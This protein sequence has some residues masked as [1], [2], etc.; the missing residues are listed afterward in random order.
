MVKKGM[1]HLRS[2][3]NRNPVSKILSEGS[4]V[5]FKQAGVVVM[6]Q[7]YMQSVWE[8]P[9]RPCRILNAFAANTWGKIRLK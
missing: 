9:I 6:R 4:R 2:E 7:V 8:A 3:H 5:S 1:S